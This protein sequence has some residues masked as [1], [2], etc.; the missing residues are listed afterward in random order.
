MESKASNAARMELEKRA[1]EP[2]QYK[3]E[4]DSNKRN[5][6][7]AWPKSSFLLKSFLTK[8]N[9]DQT[10]DHAGVPNF[11]W[12][13]SIHSAPGEIKASDIEIHANYEFRRS[14]EYLDERYGYRGVDYRV[15][16]WARIRGSRICRFSISHIR[17]VNA[18]AFVI[19]EHGGPDNEDGD[20]KNLH[21]YARGEGGQ[22]TVRFS[23]RPDEREEFQLT[24]DGEGTDPTSTPQSCSRSFQAWITI[25]FHNP[26]IVQSLPPEDPARGPLDK[27][28][29]NPNSTPHPDGA[30]LKIPPMPSRTIAKHIELKRQTGTE[31]EASDAIRELNRIQKQRRFCARFLGFGRFFLNYFTFSLAEEEHWAVQVIVDP[32]NLYVKKL[33]DP[34]KV[35]SFLPGRDKVP[36][37]LGRK[38]KKLDSDD[39]LVEESQG[40]VEKFLEKVNQVEY[41][42]PLY[43]SAMVKCQHQ[44]KADKSANYKYFKELVKYIDSIDKLPSHDE[45]AKK[46]AEDK[47]EKSFLAIN[48]LKPDNETIMTILI[49]TVNAVTFIYHATW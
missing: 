27:D 15:T 46:A 41:S 13:A 31:K 42:L 32:F 7:K 35:P 34:T 39:L 21:A 40:D 16:G 48:N 28:F 33:Y 22:F 24:N 14:F 45:V 8:V 37:V 36:W 12:N 18:W 9:I 5:H 30:A 44:L 4:P 25:E 20:Q 1:D 3:E 19:N 2:V 38:K 49:E 11:A 6:R 10:W 29:K 23:C 17:T 43:L 26:D 47:M